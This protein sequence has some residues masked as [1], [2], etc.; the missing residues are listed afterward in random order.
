MLAAQATLSFAD[1]ADR[2]G[3]WEVL[4]MPQYTT[5]SGLNGAY[6]STADIDGAFGFGFGVAYNL[7][8]HLSLGGDFVWNSSNYK[9]T[10]VP[11]P[12]NTGTSYSVS[13]YL[14]TSTLR[15]NATWNFLQTPLT[16]FVT[17]GLGATYVDT[18]V[19][20]GPP[21]TICWW[22][23][24]WG[25]YCSTSSPTHNETEFS[26]MAGA[27]VRWDV[28][29]QFFLRG[30]AARQWLQVGGGLGTPGFTQYRVDIGFKF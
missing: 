2:A 14:E 11:A 13:G 15:L 17:G 19:P 5:S 10:V 6:G 4:L 12:G 24:W 27:G 9:A 25:Y 8:D 1:S 23:P 26:Y 29:R 3:K 16:P 20:T 21:S 30:V 22:D 28:S 7:N 18:N